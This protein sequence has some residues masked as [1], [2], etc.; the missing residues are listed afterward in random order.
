LNYKFI[1]GK[2]QNKL[3][4]LE[5]IQKHNIDCIVHFA[6]QSHVDTSFSDSLVFT[7]D[8]V[9]A[10]HILLECC[11]LAQQQGTN[12]IKK[13]IH[14]STDEVYGDSTLTSGKSNEFNEV[15]KTEDS[16]LNPTNPYAA[17]KAAAEML[18]VAYYYSFK[19]PIIITRGNNV[20]GPCQYKEKLIP[21]FIHLLLN[22]EKC[23]IHG[24]GAYLRSF[25]HT[26]DVCTAIETILWRG[27][28][29]ETYNIGSD[30]EYTVNQIAD[31][32]I[33]AIKSPTDSNA[34]QSWKEFVQDRV[35]NDT[36]YLISC[37]KLRCL[38]WSQS[39]PFCNG[40]M[41]TIEWYKHKFTL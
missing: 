24:N 23:T 7:D 36:R 34:L 10:T 26:Y 8:N 35:F 19:L 40:I 4:L 25:I 3:F 22:D 31:I 6:A 38:G 39:V 14:I 13:F 28:I 21:K 12:T 32:L 20:Y 27:C 18:C 33:N 16:P 2:L 11:K 29:G 41:S 5:F 15:C 17:T 37:D 30:D 9:I 1:Y